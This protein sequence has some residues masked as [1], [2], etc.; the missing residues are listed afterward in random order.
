M[1]TIILINHVNTFY[2]LERTSSIEQ[3]VWLNSEERIFRPN[4][5]ETI[6]QVQTVRPVTLHD[7]LKVCAV[8][9]DDAAL[10]SKVWM[11]ASTI[12]F[13]FVSSSGVN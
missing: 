9:A 8:Y 11:N 12:D 10:G 3:F 1:T 13:N 5:T 7:A 2:T 6:V 4:I